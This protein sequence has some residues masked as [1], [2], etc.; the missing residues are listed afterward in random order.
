MEKVFVSDSLSVGVE[1]NFGFNSIPYSKIKIESYE[2]TLVYL[3][4]CSIFVFPTWLCPANICYSIAST[5]T[6]L[7]LKLPQIA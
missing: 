2:F 3:R 7:W 5:T 1:R 6:S 4:K